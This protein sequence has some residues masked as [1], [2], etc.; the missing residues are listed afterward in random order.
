MQ[1]DTWVA[2]VLHF[3]FVELTPEQWWKSDPALDARIGAQFL[4]LH[5]RVAATNNVQATTSAD[6]ALAAVIVLDQFPRNIFRNSARAFATDSVALAIAEF[7]IAHGFDL[8]LPPVRRQFLYMPFMHAE[9]RAAQER[10][11]ALVTTLGDK[12]AVDAA[13][14][15]KSI[16]DRFGRYPH[17]N[18]ALRRDTT[19][20]EH[21]YLDGKAERFG[22]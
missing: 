20:E 11:V 9:D 13:L 21:A 6:E 3:W 7:A 14:K 4:P 2:D 18:A 15:H 5:E 12:E 22:Q 17:R 1:N 16:I 8:L 10:A 19:A